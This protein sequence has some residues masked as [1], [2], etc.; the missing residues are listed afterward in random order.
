MFLG[1]CL[2]EI[3]DRIAQIRVF[4]CWY[5]SV[6]ICLFFVVKATF[7]WTFDIYVLYFSHHFSENFIFSLTKMVRKI[8]NG[9]RQFP[10]YC[11]YI[12]LIN[13]ICGGN[14]SES[15]TYENHR[16]ATSHWQTYNVLS[17]SGYKRES[18][19]RSNQIPYDHDRYDP[20]I[21]R[22]WILCCIFS[23]EKGIWYILSHLSRHVII[24]SCVKS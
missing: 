1:T 20:S 2:L 17:T 4:L 23:I 14:R 16:T 11:I 19:T 5:V 15:S 10:K 12:V 18:E 6:S 9:K 13:F 21:D 3:L 8:M 24:F 7:V 22:G